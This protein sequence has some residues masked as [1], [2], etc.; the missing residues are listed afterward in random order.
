MK[1]LVVDDEADLRE[2]LQFNLESEGYTVDVASSAEEALG[3][4]EPDHSLI[5]LDV[6]MGEMSG[7]KMAER[8]R[9][10]LF[11][12]VPI[13]FLTAK[14][15]EN[16]LLT[17]FSVGGDDYITKPFSI[18]ELLV[19]TKALLK[20]ASM[21]EENGQQRDTVQIGELT[22]NVITK[23]VTFGGNTMLLTKKEYEILLL[24]ARANG[25]FLSREVILDKVW[26]DTFVA[27]RT[28]DV[29]ITNLRKKLADT[30][31]TVISRTNYGYSLEEK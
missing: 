26:G 14:T 12:N 6:M 2:I 5:I 30:K 10:E 25:R 7:Y 17:G 3:V 21:A 11:N 4:L 19:R 18:K 16:D 20:R 23:E 31:L 1:I 13:I 8:L 15:Q 24:L 27:E 9:K 22:I 29:H 28:V